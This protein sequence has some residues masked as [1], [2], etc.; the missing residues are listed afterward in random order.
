MCDLQAEAEGPGH[1]GLPVG[2]EE[3]EHPDETTEEYPVIVSSYSTW[4]ACSHSNK[5]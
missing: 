5:D 3:H 1:V 4:N 2:T